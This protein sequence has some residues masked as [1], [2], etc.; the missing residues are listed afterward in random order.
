MKISNYFKLFKTQNALSV[1]YTCIGILDTLLTIVYIMFAAI[2]GVVCIH[3]LTKLP[4]ATCIIIFII[5]DVLIS[6][7]YRL[8]GKYIS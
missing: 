6:T 7:A 4:I 2:G 3:Y 8:I 1:A 5:C